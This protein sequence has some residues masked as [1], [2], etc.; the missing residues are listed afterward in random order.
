MIQSGSVHCVHC[1][2]HQFQI[3]Q[4]LPSHFY[5]VGYKGNTS[6]IQSGSVHCGMHQFQSHAQGLPGYFYVVGTKFCGLNTPHISNN[7][8]IKTPTFN[9]SDFVPIKHTHKF[10]CHNNNYCIIIV[11]GCQLTYSTQG[12]I[13]TMYAQLL[14]MRESTTNFIHCFFLSALLLLCI[15]M[16]MRIRN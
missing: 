11:P 16:L 15:T 2:M 6:L 9:Y 1:G 10:T 4:G 8:G 13:C 14:H 7:C 3:P 12:S 5:V